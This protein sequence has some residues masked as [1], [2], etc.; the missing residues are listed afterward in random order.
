[1]EGTDAARTP[2]PD[3]H[4]R[5]KGRRSA[6]HARQCRVRKPLL[7]SVARAPRS[8]RDHRAVD[9]IDRPPRQSHDPEVLRPAFGPVIDPT[10]LTDAVSAG[11]VD[12]RPARRR[13]VLLIGSNRAGGCSGR[14]H[15]GR[16][17][18][19]YARQTQTCASVPFRRAYARHV[20]HCRRHRRA[21]D[22]VAACRGRA[23][24]GHSRAGTCTH[25]RSN[26]AFPFRHT[27]TRSRSARPL[28]RQTYDETAATG[29]WPAYCGFP[30]AGHAHRATDGAA[31]DRARAARGCGA[32]CDAIID[33]VGVPAR[34]AGSRTSRYSA[35]PRGR[36]SGRSPAGLRVVPTR[37]AGA[38]CLAAT[39]GS[40]R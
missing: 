18:R 40:P 35:P 17:R 12:G 19:S 11:P 7:R 8:I 1:V 34:A 4:S 30:A 38:G 14:A 39:A 6:D 36:S 9:L 32:A 31:R 5:R 15:G 22:R 27:R 3:A 29:P 24:R 21:P 33:T 10:G 2:I 26:N 28:R 37:R 20:R 16:P 23:G 25:Q 13:R